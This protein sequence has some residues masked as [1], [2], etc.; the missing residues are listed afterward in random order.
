MSAEGKAARRSPALEVLFPADPPSDYPG[1][2][3]LASN[4]NGCL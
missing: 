3:T 2:N 1:S 4:E